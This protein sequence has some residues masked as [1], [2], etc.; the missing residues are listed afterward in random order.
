MAVC[1]LCR[2]SFLG[3][4]VR[5]AVF[6]FHLRAWLPLSQG[7]FISLALVLF[8]LVKEEQPLRAEASP[9]HPGA[10]FC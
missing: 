7:R 10:W 9:F 4:T 1:G 5:W 6:P 2:P 8:W 3:P